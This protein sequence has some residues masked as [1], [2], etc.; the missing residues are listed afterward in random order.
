MKRMKILHIDIETAPM[1]AAVWQLR[2]D[3]IPIGHIIKDG[4]TLCFA[5]KWEGTNKVIFDSVHESKPKDMIKRAYD[6]IG[7][8]DAICHY[9]GAKF[10]MP[11]LNREFLLQGLKPVDIV[12]IDLL[13]V[14]RKNFRFDSNKLD[15][16]S[17]RL[18]LG[19]KT[20]HVGMQLWR[21]CM[22][23]DDNAW[24]IMKKYNKQDVILL[25]SLYHKL[26]PWIDNHPNMNHFKDTGDSVCRNC[27]SKKITKYGFK[28]TATGVFQRY[29]CQ[30]CGRIN[31]SRKQ[32]VKSIGVV[33]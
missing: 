5:A 17:Q 19:A 22:D 13:R 16:V 31:R 29:Q 11:I 20:K 26:L 3:Y 12:N 21:D 23:G 15:Y 24:A 6:L 7:Q 8:A 25:E 10:D 4:Y 30:G 18:G 33:I 14:V 2:T 9:N 32:S 27:G 1:L 28:M